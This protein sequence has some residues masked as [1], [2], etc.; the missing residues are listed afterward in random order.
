MAMS[1]HVRA[2]KPFVALQKLT[3]MLRIKY[4][5]YHTSIQVEPL[6]TEFSLD[7][8]PCDNDKV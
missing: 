7:A 5:I 6:S 2:G 1:A 3:E 4:N 8:S